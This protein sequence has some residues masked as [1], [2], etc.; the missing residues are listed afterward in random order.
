[1]DVVSFFYC[2]VGLE[3]EFR[4]YGMLI[5]VCFVRE[6]DIDGL[7]FFFIVFGFLLYV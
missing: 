1:M 7:V 6:G 3:L 2:G 5:M 4:I